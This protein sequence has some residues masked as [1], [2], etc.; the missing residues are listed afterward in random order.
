MSSLA[1]K[2]PHMMLERGIRVL[3]PILD[4][5]GFHFNFQ[6]VGQGSGGPYA[7]GEFVREERCLE[8]ARKRA[9][10]K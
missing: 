7:R 8:L 5:H 2:D 1:M 10:A 3:D 6:S 9:G 4:P